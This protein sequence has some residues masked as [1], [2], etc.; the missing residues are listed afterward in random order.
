MH[1]IVRKGNGEYYTSA[2]FGYYSDKKEEYNYGAYYI[3]F[4]ENKEH[5]IKQQTF[6]PRK[7]PQLDLM[8]LIVDSDETG[9]QEDEHGFGG[10]D[11]LSKD[12]A[13]MIVREGQCSEDVLTKCRELDDRY[14]YSEYNEIH[15]DSDI[16]RLMIVSGWFHD[17][18]IEEIEDKDGKLRVLFDGVWGCKI[19]MFFE[20]DVSYNTDSRDPEQYDPYWYGSTMIRQDG[21]IYF[22]DDDDMKVEDIMEGYCWFKAQKVSY[23][24]IPD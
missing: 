16:E 22:V 19:E 13:L 9:W 4:D 2:V 24:V 21:Y 7:K 14:H 1:A 18:V 5:L 15:D 17:A 12:D 6:D 20:G 11:F 8:I 23:H 10:V 3:V